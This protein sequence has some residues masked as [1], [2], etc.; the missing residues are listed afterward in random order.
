MF[1]RRTKV[2]RGLDGKSYYTFRLVENQRV[3]TKSGKKRCS[4]SMQ[5]GMFPGLTG[6]RLPIEW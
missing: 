3:G 4:I 5:T 1:I 2:V 6:R